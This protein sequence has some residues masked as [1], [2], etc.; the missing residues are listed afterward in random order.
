M[1]QSSFNILIKTPRPPITIVQ[2]ITELIYNQR[3]LCA[4]TFPNTLF[5]GASQFHCTV[6]ARNKLF[7]PRLFTHTHT[8]WHAGPAACTPGIASMKYL[9]FDRD[10]TILKFVSSRAF[11]ECSRGDVCRV[12]HLCVR[13]LK[14]RRV[15][16]HILC[17]G[18]TMFVC[19]RKS[20]IS[21]VESRTLAGGV[22]P[23]AKRVHLPAY[24]NTFYIII[25]FELL[26]M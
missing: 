24:Y 17:A 22:V 10:E 21:A 13:T 25:A 23:E 14:C 19:A 2:N 11:F 7:R 18:K 12:A 4:F 1:N 3:V 16:V 5:C 15:C 26:A 9:F 20:R 6:V 8:R